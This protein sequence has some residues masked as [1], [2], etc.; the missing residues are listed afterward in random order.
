MLNLTPDTAK[1]LLAD[2]QVGSDLA[3]RNPFQYM[4]RVFEEV[5][6]PLGGRFELRIHKTLLEPEIIALVGRPQQSFHLVITLEQCRKRLLRY[7]PECAALQQLNIL[8]RG[9]LR[10][11]AMKGS[12]EVIL[13]C[14]P[15]RDLLAIEV[16]IA[17]NGALLEEV[18]ITTGLTL[19]EEVA[20]LRED[21]LCEA[22][23]QRLLALRAELVKL[24]EVLK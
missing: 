16:I 18:K 3:Q 4:R 19:G 17:A 7:G 14:E 12:D 9:L 2:A 5:L 10:D 15:M 6:I 23:L 20:I 13:E 8:H 1:R 11:E 24:F 22:I 21:D